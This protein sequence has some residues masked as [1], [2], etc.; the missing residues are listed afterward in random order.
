MLETFATQLMD[1]ADRIDQ[2]TN[3]LAASRNLDELK[4]KPLGTLPHPRP[5]ASHSPRQTQG[6]GQLRRGA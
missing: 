1:L 6:F 4:V 2:L 3:H 5:F